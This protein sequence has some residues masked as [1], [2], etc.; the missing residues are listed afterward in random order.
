MA[1]IFKAYDVRGTYP[2]QLNESIARQIGLAFQV[3]LDGEDRA[4]GNEVVVSRDMRSSS[5]PLQ[6]EL[7]LG[8]RDAGLDVVD[9]GL[10]TT[11]MNY[12][13]VGYLRTS[14]GVQTTASH[15]PAQYNGFKFSKSDARPVS[16][17]EGIPEIERHVQA[18]DLAA[19][20]TPGKLRTAEVF[21]AYG[22]RVLSFLQ[23]PA[24]ARPL[25]VVVDAGNGMSTI[26]RPLL[27]RTGI[28]LVPLFFE[29][30]G[31]FPN[32]EANPLKLENLRDL[33]AEVKRTGADLGVSFDGDAD[34]AAFVDE[35]GEP[36]GSDLATALIAG[37]LLAKEPGKHVVYDLRSS[38]ATPEWIREKGGIPVRERV[39]HSFMKATLRRLGG[40]M[41]GEL[42]GHYYF[43]D[44]YHADSALLAVVHV[45]NL[46]WE[47][48][49]KMSQLVAPLHRYAKSPEINFEVEDKEGMM[50]ALASRYS[51][52]EIDH[53][54][55]VTVQYPDWWFNVRPSNTEPLLR[56]VL[57]AQTPEDLA[58]RE[59]ELIGQLGEPVSH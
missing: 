14:G 9:I 40:I 26:Y 53:L 30:D 50:R 37:E 34:R 31:T 27:E 41:G 29:L 38:R 55:G 33:C 35:T 1:G 52:G 2:D 42:A 13:A 18:G 5:A 16:G 20:P 48:G 3:V 25:K 46:L 44:M 59:R 28:E 17:D 45:L 4:R 22:D 32:H 58:K 11:P 43:R 6:A 8:L 57:E 39:G 47:S 49:Q 10:A 36:L 7:T 12:F 54:D 56:L 15:N 23:R 51:N 19:A 21:A 24:Q